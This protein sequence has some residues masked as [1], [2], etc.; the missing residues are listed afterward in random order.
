M[1]IQKYKLASEQDTYLVWEFCCLKPS[2]K[3]A[4]LVLLNHADFELCSQKCPS[5]SDFSFSMK[6]LSSHNSTK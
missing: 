2:N 4:M 5:S 6:Y 1:I 3:R